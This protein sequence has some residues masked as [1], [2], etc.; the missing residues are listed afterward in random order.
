LN[1]GL[2]CAAVA[3]LALAA[4]TSAGA[5]SRTLPL[6][7]HVAG[8]KVGGLR[9]AAA[10]RTVNAAFARPFEVVVDGRTFVVRPPRLATAYTDGAVRR[11]AAA[12][13][14]ENVRLVVNVHGNAVRELVERIARNVEHHAA[15][16]ENALVLRNGKPYVA[17]RA[18]G[19][20]LDGGLVPAVSST[21]SAPTRAGR[22]ASRRAW[23]SRAC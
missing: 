17:P 13:P 23:C 10:A 7:V 20:R 3:V 1:R 19:R 4:A 16:G 15:R 12:S 6:R 18:F 5:A 21:S 8:V 2:F 14:G 9:P 11:A 22:C